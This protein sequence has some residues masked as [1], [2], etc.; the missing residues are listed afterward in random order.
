MLSVEGT[1][2]AIL[3]WTVFFQVTDIRLRSSSLMN[4]ISW[5]ILESFTRT[6]KTI[7]M[8]SLKLNAVYFISQPNSSH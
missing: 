6:V 7:L 3:G 2:T 1:T 4:Y 8:G 5:R